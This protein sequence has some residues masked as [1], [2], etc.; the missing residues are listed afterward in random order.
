MCCADRY[1]DPR[2][3]VLTFF[4][5]MDVSEL[6]EKPAAA[7]RSIP[8]P[9]AVARRGS[10]GRR[11]PRHRRGKR[12]YWVCRCGRFR[13]DRSRRR[14]A[15]YEELRKRFGKSV[16]LVH[17]R[18][19]ARRTRHGALC[20]RQ[21]SVVVATTVIEVGVD[22][23]EATIMVIEH[24]ERFALPTASVARTVGRGAG[25]STCLLLYKARSARPPSAARILRETEDGFRIAE[26]DLRLRGEG[27]LLGTRQ[28]ACPAST[29]HA[30]R[31][32]ENI[33]RGARR[34]R[35]GA[36]PRPESGDAARP[37]AASPALS[38]RQG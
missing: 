36:Q 19:K 9:F 7:S 3:L 6:R 32:T 13:K 25:R 2:T 20:R 22:V 38:V 26:E 1:A 18:M 31:R 14:E 10:R 17:G 11:R 37:S 28:A 33:W 34:R 23:P 12:A 35:A 27:D 21:E 4:G 8:A 5:D 15:R 24:A 30:S 16:D 29:S